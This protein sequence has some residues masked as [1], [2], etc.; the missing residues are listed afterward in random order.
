MTSLR[1]HALNAVVLYYELE[2]DKAGRYFVY[3]L[4]MAPKKNTSQN[5]CYIYLE[6]QRLYA[7][8]DSRLRPDGIR[9]HT[10]EFSWSGLPKG[11]GAH[12]PEA[13]RDNQVYFEIQDPGIYTLRIISRSMRFKLDKIVLQPEN[14]PPG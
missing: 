9:V 14:L 4:C 7:L 5:D 8:G 10:D 1:I 6:N 3:L 12:T 2:F 13:I 11:P